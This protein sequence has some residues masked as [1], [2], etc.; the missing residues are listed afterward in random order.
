MRWNLVSKTNLMGIFERTIFMRSKRDYPIG[1]AF[2]RIDQLAD[3][4]MYG[5][6]VQ[7]EKLNILI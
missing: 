3:L 6:C 4:Q 1:T 2:K 7:L 5:Y